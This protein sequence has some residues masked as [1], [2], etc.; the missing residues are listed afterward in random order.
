MILVI[1]GS[2][3]LCVHSI[4]KKSFLRI[5]MKCSDTNSRIEAIN[6]FISLF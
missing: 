4:Q 6:C 3:D 2:Q 5:K 1:I